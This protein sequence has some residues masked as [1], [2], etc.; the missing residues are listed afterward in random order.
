MSCRFIVNVHL[1]HTLEQRIHIDRH[2]NNEGN[3]E[4]FWVLITKID[5]DND[6]ITGT[7]NNH[8]QL[9]GL[10]IDDEIKLKRKHIF[11]VKDD[12][13]TQQ[14]QQFSFDPHIGKYYT[15]QYCISQRQEGGYTAVQ[16]NIII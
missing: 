8:V 11:I 14:W 5:S 7:V 9:A 1:T 13:R 3:A 10:Q 2:L 16:I 15:S 12:T 6:T 4:S